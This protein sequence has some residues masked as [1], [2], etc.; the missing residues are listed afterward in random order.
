M[1][2]MS[3]MLRNASSFFQD[4]SGW[5]VRSFYDSFEAL[6][7]EVSQWNEL[8][9]H[10]NVVSIFDVPVRRVHIEQ[11]KMAFAIVDHSSG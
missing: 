1:K 7:G 9:Q 6:G 2:S 11:R 8:M 10:T 5:N 3:R 4:L